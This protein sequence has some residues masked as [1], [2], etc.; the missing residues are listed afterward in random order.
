MIKHIN[1]SRYK[2]LIDWLKAARNEQGLTVRD[3]G[4]LLG[5]PHQFVV[6]IETCERKLNV[7]EYVQYCDVL[8][9]PKEKG[10]DILS[11]PIQ[12]IY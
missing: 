4:K 12:S 2:A 3:L 5:E 1:D 11:T 8:N 6:R 7:F 9:L 10:L